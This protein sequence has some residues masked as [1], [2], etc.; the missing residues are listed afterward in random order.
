[1]VEQDAATGEQPIGFA[2]IDRGPVGEQL[3]D[4]VRAA[5]VEEGGLGLRHFVNLA[6]HFRGGGLV[7]ADFRIDDADGFHQVQGPEAGDVSGGY[8]LLERDA[9]EALS[10]EV[11][12]LI[13]LGLLE[14]SDAG[15]GIG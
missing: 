10:G 9:D 6:V 1:M 3:G 8:G 14:H 13:R 4:A 2:V 12:N 11:V 7:E 15:A 5:G